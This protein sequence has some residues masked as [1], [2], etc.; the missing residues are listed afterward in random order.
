MELA[1][2][3]VVGAIALLHLYILVL[4]MFLWERAKKAF[5]L[6]GADA[7]NPRFRTML[8][9]QGIYNGFLAAGLAWGLLHPDPTLGWQIQLFFVSCVGVA[10]VVGAVTAKK[11]ILFIQ[12]VP[13]AIALVLLLLR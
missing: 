2:N 7:D 1:A 11:E 9:N 3:V 4:E 8:I 12:T 13:S 10:G 5:R 6:D